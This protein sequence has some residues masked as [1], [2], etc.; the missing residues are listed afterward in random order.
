[1]HHAQVAIYDFQKGTAEETVQRALETAYPMYR[2]R[3]GFIAYELILTSE[4]S[5]IAV[6]TWETGEQAALAADLD[7][8]WAADHGASTV[9][10]V[11]EYVGAVKFASRKE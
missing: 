7:E 10:W 5:A 4:T 6:T 3:T 8:R 9:G 2:D 1:M 11:Q